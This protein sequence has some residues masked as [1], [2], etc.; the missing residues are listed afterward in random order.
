M[1]NNNLK[2][3]LLKVVTGAAVSS[4][5]VLGVFEGSVISNVS[6][7]EAVKAY[8]DSLYTE[9]DYGYVIVDN[10]YVK[11]TEYFGNNEEVIIPEKIN[12]LE[13][14]IIGKSAFAEYE[15]SPY[16]EIKSVY[17]PST[18]KII[19]EQ[20]FSWC[21]KLEKVEMSE[22][23]EKIG[24]RVFSSC[25]SLKSINI[26]SSVSEIDD[27]AFYYVKLENITVDENNKKY[28]SRDNCNAIIETASDKLVIGCCKTVIPSSVTSIGEGAFYRQS[29]LTNI[30]IPS[31]VKTIEKYAFCE[32]P[33]LN[34]VEIADGLKSI[35]ECAFWNCDK[36]TNVTFPSSV[37]VIGESAFALCNNLNKV[38]LSEGLTKIGKE[39]FSEC[40]S[41]KSIY[42]PST[43]NVIGTYAFCE[44]GL[45]SIS[46]STENKNYDSRNNCNAIIRTATDGL[47]CGSS[48]TQIPSDVKIIGGCAFEKCDITNIT[49]PSSVESIGNYAFAY[50][51]KLKNVTISNGVTRIGGYAFESCKSLIS[52][53]VPSSVTTIGGYAFATNG[54]SFKI[55]CDKESYAHKYAVKY[56]N[57]YELNNKITGTT[58][59]TK[60]ASAKAQSFKLNAKSTG[61]KMIYKSDNKNIKVDGTGKVIIAKNYSGKAVI[62]ITTESKVFTKVTKKITI[63]V[64]PAATTLKSVKNSSKGKITVTWNKL[65]YVNGYQIQYSTT[66]DFKSGTNKLVKVKGASNTSKVI[67]GLTKNKTY[68]V[69]IRTY[70]S[71]YGKYVYSNWSAKKTVKIGK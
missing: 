10:S 50:C 61:G 52:V 28:D 30:S 63:T 16:E 18:V 2:R 1:I 62:T 5:M 8:D 60:T 11:I 71:I 41:L 6:G 19:E 21:E 56:K 7:I 68:Y 20:A 3:Q 59:Y 13:V 44:T 12:G 39:A 14:R 33:E 17:I 48:K 58:S 47:V 45:E 65:S 24:P 69:R 9:D 25:S 29:K 64:K 35:G 27:E 31:S 54:E 67:S 26:P 43:V 66:S 32:C 38:E 34:S 4:C 37:T 53:K 57:K 23:I 22:G 42:I 40:D 15:D 70:K 55:I 49:I 36:L 51:S 46:V